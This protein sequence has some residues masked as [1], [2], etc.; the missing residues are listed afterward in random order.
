[1]HLKLTLIHHFMLE[2][3][4]Y[5]FIYVCHLIRYAENYHYLHYLILFRMLSPYL[6]FI[7]SF[8]LLYLS[9]DCIQLALPS[10]LF[11]LQMTLYPL[12]FMA[13]K[14]INHHLCSPTKFFFLL[15]SVSDPITATATFYLS[16]VTLSK[17]P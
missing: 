6:V 3:H 13:R 5:L 8:A 15:D 4:K 17:Q 11:L 14:V 12:L 10:P 7:F 9:L 1:M 2:F 16:K